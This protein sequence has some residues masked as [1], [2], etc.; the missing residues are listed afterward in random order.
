M[1]IVVNNLPKEKRE[2]V[3]KVGGFVDFL[4]DEHELFTAT[5]YHHAIESNSCQVRIADDLTGKKI[6]IDRFEFDTIEI[7]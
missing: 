7:S 6:I 4:D 3:V 2:A 1:E 5:F